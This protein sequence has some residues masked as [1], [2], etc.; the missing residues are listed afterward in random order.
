MHGRIGIHRPYYEVPK[1]EITA[2]KITEQFQTMLKEL[3][4]YF[5]E[6][7][8]NEQLADTM[9]RIE[10]ERMRV[11]NHAE[12]N[13]YGLTTEDPIAR[14]I[15]ELKTAQKYGLSRQEYMSRKAL[16][17]TTLADYREW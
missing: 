8:V 12:L 1:G 7:N 5:H 10:P 14:E 3:R 17:S 16:A 6:M 15:N 11:L 4:A 9:L 2:D 13:R